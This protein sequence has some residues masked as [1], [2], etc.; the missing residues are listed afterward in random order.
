[1]LDLLFLDGMCHAESMTPFRR[2]GRYGI[3]PYI[4]LL[5]I[6]FLG[7]SDTTATTDM[8]GDFDSPLSTDRDSDSSTV[9]TDSLLKKGDATALNISGLLNAPFLFQGK[10]WGR[11]S[12]GFLQLNPTF[13]CMN[14]AHCV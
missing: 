14:K 1:M 8:D 2:A 5:F 7:C 10:G 4:I 6:L 12:L 3:Y 13:F 11:V 9:D